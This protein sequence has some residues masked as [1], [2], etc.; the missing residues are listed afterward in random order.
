MGE[1]LR[2][3]ARDTLATQ[4]EAVAAIMDVPRLL[5]R[6]ADP[7]PLD[8]HDRAVLFRASAVSHW[9]TLHEVSLA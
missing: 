9:A 1:W 6:C 8:E 2:R 3:H 7:A 4:G 5:R